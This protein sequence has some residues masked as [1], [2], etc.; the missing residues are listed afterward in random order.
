MCSC[1]RAH[2]CVY[3]RAFTYVCKDIC[4]C[5]HVRMY[6][7]TCVC[8]CEY[9][10]MNVQHAQTCLG[11]T[12]GTG[13]LLKG[14]SAAP[15]TPNQKKINRT[16][17]PWFSF[18]CLKHICAVAPASPAPRWNLHLFEMYTIII[19]VLEIH[20]HTEYSD[21]HKHAHICTSRGKHC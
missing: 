10:R 12:K 9:V 15:A 13:S 6:V 5:V 3:A 16:Q 20:S 1:V 19:D 11:G 21:I 2:A 7:R 18:E 14:R 8:A 4:K 17:E